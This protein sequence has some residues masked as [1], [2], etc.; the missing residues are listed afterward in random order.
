MMQEPTRLPFRVPVI[1]T[2][3]CPGLRLFHFIYNGGCFYFSLFETGIGSKAPPVGSDVGTWGEY[4]TCENVHRN[5]RIVFMIYVS[6]PTTV[7]ISLGLEDLKLCCPRSSKLISPPTVGMPVSRSVL[8][9]R[10]SYVAHDQI[11]NFH[12]SDDFF[13]LSCALSD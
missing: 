5:T 13:I 4:R 2:T 3:E 6:H 9:V 8:F 12:S 11:L 1:S 10:H 7:T